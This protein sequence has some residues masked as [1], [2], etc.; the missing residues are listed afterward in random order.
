[1]TATTEGSGQEQVTEI[2]GP[3]TK[4]LEVPTGLFDMAVFSLVAQASADATTIS[5]KISYDAELVAEQT[6]TGAYSV[7]S[8]S[9]SSE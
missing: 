5:C 9:G 8:C 3:F 2:P 4:E 7:V 1:M 6:S